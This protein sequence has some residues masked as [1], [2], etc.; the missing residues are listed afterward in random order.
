MSGFV[1]S[2][3]SWVYDVGLRKLR[4]LIPQ[5]RR[6]IAGVTGKC[7]RTAN[8]VSQCILWGVLCN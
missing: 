5:D 2:A 8:S 7:I 1:T 3:R 4:H 6:L